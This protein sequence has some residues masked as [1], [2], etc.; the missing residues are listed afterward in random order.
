MASIMRTA[1]VARKKHLLG[2]LLVLFAAGLHADDRPIALIPFWGGDPQIT[3]EFGRVLYNGIIE[4]GGFAPW[5][6]D[7]GNLPPDVPVG[8]FP[9][10]VSPGPSKTRGMPFAMTGELLFN[11]DTGMHM[12]RLYLWEMENNRLLFSDEMGAFDAEGLGFVMPAM[13]EWLFSWIPDEEEHVCDLTAWA[14][15]HWLYLGVRGG[16]NLQMFNQLWSPD[17]VEPMDWGDMSMAIQVAFSP[18][19]FANALPGGFILQPA[20]QIEGIF[21]QDFAHN[22][23]TF[24]MPLMVRLTARNFYTSFSI[25]GGLFFL[26][27]DGP[28]I[29]TDTGDTIQFGH[30]SEGRWGGT[31]GFSMGQRLGPGHL[32]GDVRWSADM[33]STIRT[34]REPPGTFYYHRRMVSITI[35]YEFGLIR[36]ER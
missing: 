3:I 20:I 9:P 5:V 14:D 1:I 30:E 8:G 24:T 36:R 28:G 18:I 32:I 34:F 35:G 29:G 4:M 11:N 26:L 19:H 23:A 15:P 2:C 13:L 25:F 16:W 31:F 6:V 27:G 21:M 17:I 22:A 10:F 12:L 33:F 7:L